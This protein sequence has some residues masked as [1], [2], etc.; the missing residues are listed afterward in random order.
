MEINKKKGIIFLS[1]GVF[2]ISAALV[3]TSLGIMGM[4]IPNINISKITSIIF[5]VLGPL[6]FISS[7]IFLF[8][9]F[10]FTLKNKS[11]KYRTCL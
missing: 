6:F 11:K 7:F 10:S 3:L 5:L 4:C 9:G 1:V 8:F 2:I